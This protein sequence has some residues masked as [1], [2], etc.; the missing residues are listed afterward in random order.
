MSKLAKGRF[1]QARVDLKADLEVI[2]LLAASSPEQVED[3]AKLTQVALAA[4]AASATEYLDAG[5]AMGFG[6]SRRGT[7]RARSD[8]SDMSTEDLMKL[9]AEDTDES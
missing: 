3:H 6:N 2:H 8:G 9:V 4:M 5:E 1:T 7:E